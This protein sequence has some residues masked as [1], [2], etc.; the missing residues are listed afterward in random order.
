MAVASNDRPSLILVPVDRGGRAMDGLLLV[1][2]LSW[3]TYTAAYFVLHPQ[4]LTFDPSLFMYLTGKPDPACGLTRTFA[5]MWRGDVISAVRVY[6]LGP[7]LFVA[8]INSAASVIAGKTFRLEMSQRAI[9][10]GL[11]IVAAAFAANWA[12]KLIWLGM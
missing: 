4:G 12:S 7:L 9:R 3:L 1:F 6:P 11:I 8:T 5:W 2:A 10:I